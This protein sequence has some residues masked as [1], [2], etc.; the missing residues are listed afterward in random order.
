MKYRKLNGTE[1][2]VSE[3]CLGTM[4]FGQQ[5]DE[6]NAHEQLDYAVAQGINFIDTAEMY[7]V[8]PEKEKQGMT[9][10]FIG[11]WL[12]KRSTRDD[13]VI[14]TKVSGPRQAGTMRTRNAAA[15]LTRENVFKAIDDSLQRLQ[16]DYVDLY[17]VHTTDRQTLNWGQR[18][19][20]KLDGKDGVP[21][22]ETLSALS[23]LVKAGKVR[24]IGVSNETPWGLMEYVRLH[25]E[26]GLQKIVTIQNNYGLM[27]RTFEVGHSEICLRENIG[28]LPYSI[29]NRGVISGKYLGGSKP[30]GAKFTLWERDSERYNAKWY[31]PV[32]R[33]YIEVAQKHNLDVVQM[34]IAFCLS[35]PFIPSVI[36][37]ATK[38][39]QLKKDIEAANIKLS[40]EVFSDIAEVYKIMPD[41]TA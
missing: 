32:V 40:P 20:E 19:I 14:A 7:P 39:E 1:I 13:L 37:A 3:L 38:M 24:H 27:A 8:P 2:D 6:A 36:I 28:L 12:K 17:Q 5:C 35:R 4:N 41:P 15:G 31:E 22:E 21:I 16:T 26:K 23:E 30:P 25:R 34:A 29:L 11:R 10:E 18:G 9:E 33:R